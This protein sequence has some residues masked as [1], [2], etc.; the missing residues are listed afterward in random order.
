MDR[1][2]RTSRDVERKISE[3][4]LRNRRMPTYSE[5]TALLGVRSK[6]VVHFWV[7]KLLREGVLEKDSKGFLRPLRPAF[8][9][10]LVGEIQAGFPS[11]AEE[12]LR[13]LISLDEYLITRPESSFLLKVSGDSMVGAGIMPG[14]LVIVEKGREPKNGDVIL[15]QVDGEWTMK[16]FSKRGG[17]IFLEAANAK[18]P[19]IR[20]KEELRVGGVITA[21][22]RKYHR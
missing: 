14:D 9:L 6:S 19:P 4:F 2:R 18:Y 22:I 7:K 3:F 1:M 21:V 20:P 13:D 17:K 15:A 8:P 5:M 11:P 10:P 16:Y 12:E